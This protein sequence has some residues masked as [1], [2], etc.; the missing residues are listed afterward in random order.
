[1]RTQE[2]IIIVQCKKHGMGFNQ[3]WQKGEQSMSSK[4]KR[5]IQGGKL[6]VFYNGAVQQLR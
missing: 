3:I 6:E 2:S 1:M 4:S 5:F